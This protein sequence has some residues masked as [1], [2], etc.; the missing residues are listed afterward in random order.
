MRKLDKEL[1]SM[2]TLASLADTV[3][4]SPSDYRPLLQAFIEQTA[5]D[6]EGIRTGIEKRDIRSISERIHS[7]KG[8]ALNLGLSE[9]S[10]LTEKM[11]SLNKAEDMEGVKE[12]LY[13]CSKEVDTLMRLL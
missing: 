7:I 12:H 9:I 5:V 8:A 1:K 6:L 11:S 10:R 4:L 3:E 2:D 13:S